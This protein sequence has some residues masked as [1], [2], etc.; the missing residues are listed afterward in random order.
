MTDNTRLSIKAERKESMKNKKI[1]LY[2]LIISGLLLIFSSIVG[3]Y[4]GNEISFYG[5]VAGI[6]L[7]VIPFVYTVLPISYDYLLKINNMK[8][9]LSS[10]TFTDRYNDLQNLITALS[11]EKVIMLTGAYPQCGKSW[12]A[13]KLFDCINNPKDPEFKNINNKFIK[14]A[15]YLDMQNKNEEDIHYFF[16]NHII[17]NKTLIIIDHI[18][19]IDYI[20]SKQELYGFFLVYVTRSF[21]GTKGKPYCISEFAPEYIPDLQNNIR[22][23]YTNIDTLDENEIKVLYNL[24]SG[25][26]GKIHFLLERQEYVEWIKQ[27]NHKEQTSYDEELSAVQLELFIGEY[28]NAR[29]LL[30]IFYNKYLNV[31]FKN[32][33]L[34]YKYYLLKSDCEHLLNNYQNALD[35]LMPLKKKEL[36]I[37]NSDCTL[38]I[39]EAHYYKHLWKCDKALEI[40]K[41]IEANTISGMTDALGILVAKYFIDD[42]NVP[43]SNLDSLTVFMNTLEFCEKNTLPKSKKDL[44]K[45]ERNKSIYLYY[46]GNHTKKEILEPINSVISK[47]TNE[48]NRLLAN[49]YFIRAEINRLFQNYKQTLLDYE[50]SLER[51]NDNNIKIQVNV[52]K[53]YLKH[54]KKV[55]RLNFKG[56]LSKEEIIKLCKDKNNYG[57][58]LIHRINSIELG[59]PQKDK[60]IECFDT[61]IMTIL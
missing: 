61:R 60:I 2:L 28:A 39:L 47:Y 24:T 20:F 42:L 32:N 58:K 5:M 49:A 57:I 26:I 16:E 33:D 19:E 6:I 55:T 41:S 9:R 1:L 40:L 36:V 7:V 3:Y 22:K 50:N 13:K 17:T 10:N 52:M 34:Y 4:Q 43:N 48:N 14:K 11:Q 54:I 45:I 18:K 31:L 46:K 15:Y 44:L 53:Y 23:N 38:E 51:T 25:N 27:L 29:K 30:D 59:D 37:Y 8:N 35:I 21:I 56:S 12:L